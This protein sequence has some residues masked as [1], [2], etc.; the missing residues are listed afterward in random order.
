[1]SSRVERVDG[2]AATD[3]QPC[4]LLAGKGQIGTCLRHQDLADL[5][6]I[7]HVDVDT[8]DAFAAKGCRRPDVAVHIGADAVMEALLQG[9][10]YLPVRQLAPVVDHVPNNDR[11]CLGLMT[12]CR[13]GHIELS[14]VVREA[15]LVRLE[16]F[17]REFRER[18][19]SGIDVI[20]AGRKLQFANAALVP[21]VAAIARIGEDDAAVGR[22]H[23]GVIGRIQ[24]LALKGLRQHLGLALPIISYDT[25][26]GVLA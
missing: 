23:N 21:P 22:V 6:A 26:R 13:I 17:V 24:P 1:M 3:E 9:R 19:G 4:S 2:L 15:E 11:R 10:E 7:W 5:C 25:C 8:V 12:G 14:I 18:A 16:D 20:D